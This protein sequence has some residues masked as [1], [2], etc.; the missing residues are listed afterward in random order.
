ME[1]SMNEQ[2][3]V[4]AELDGQYWGC[5]RPGGGHGEGDVMGFGPLERARISDPR[6]CTKPTDMVYRGS[7]DESK[8]KAARLVRVTKTTTFK[9]SA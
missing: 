5:Q 2:T 4:V 9:V 8:L 1:T 7:P 3:G 6:Y